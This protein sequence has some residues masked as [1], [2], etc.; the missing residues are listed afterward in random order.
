M[1]TRTVGY[2]RMLHDAPSIDDD[3]AA[4]KSSGAGTVFVDAGGGHPRNRPKLKEC[5]ASLAAGDTLIVTSAAR[6]SHSLNHLILT[7]RTLNDG[8]IRFR[9]IAEPTLDITSDADADGHAYL[10]A[11]DDVRR[12]LLG[13]RVR[14]GLSAA[15][16]EGRRAGRPSV[17]TPE[18]MDVATEL[19]A[20][21]RSI[22]HIAGVLGVSAT[23]V[24]RALAAT[25]Y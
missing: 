23:A 13:D 21:G 4:L 11:L 19:R 17:M 12:T 16:T 2:T 22:A 24:R 7:L 25:H 5:L 15:S 20:S 14:S 10:L 8:E 9:S 6:L 3:I 18:R 1:T